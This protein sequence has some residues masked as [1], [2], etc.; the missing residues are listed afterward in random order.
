MARLE[1]RLTRR[2]MLLGQLVLDLTSL[3]ASRLSRNSDLGCQRQPLPPQRWELMEGKNR[4]A[5][6]RSRN[7]C[8]ASLRNTECSCYER[9]SASKADCSADALFCALSLER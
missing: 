2:R 3:E 8:S 5:R 1:I 9:Q 4:S 6:N 7:N